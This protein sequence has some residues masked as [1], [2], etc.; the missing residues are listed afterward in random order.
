MA[1]AVGEQAIKGSS[2]RCPAATV[3][4]TWFL[5]EKSWFPQPSP[6]FPEVCGGRVEGPWRSH[7][8]KNLP[9]FSPTRFSLSADFSILPALPWELFRL[10]KQAL[11]V[12]WFF[13]SH[14]P[15]L[16]SISPSPIPPRAMLPLPPANTKASESAQGTPSAPDTKQMGLKRL[17]QIVFFYFIE[18]LL[19]SP[20]PKAALRVLHQ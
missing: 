18:T 19:S 3:Q 14:P 4:N 5:E 12:R 13:P 20:L 10:D 17:V 2:T 1:K 9:R 7:K 8:A 6:D 16:L 11:S 15:F